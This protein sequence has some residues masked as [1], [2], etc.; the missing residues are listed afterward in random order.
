VAVLTALRNVLVQLNQSVANSSWLALVKRALFSAFF[1]CIICAPSYAQG[2]SSCV[3]YHSPQAFSL[4]HIADGDSFSIKPKQKVRILGID[5]YEWQQSHW[6]EL[7]K[8]RLTEL[9][10]KKYNQEIVNEKGKDVDTYK[11]L[12]RHVFSDKKN[13][14]ESLLEQGLVFP[15]MYQLHGKWQTCYLNIAKRAEKASKGIWKQIEWH[16]IKSI[17]AK[18][19]QKLL[20]NKWRYWVNAKITKISHNNKVVVVQLQQGAVLLMQRQVYLRFKQEFDQI[21][22]SDNIKFRAKVKSTK[23]QLKFWINHIADIHPSQ[24]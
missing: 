2:Q 8:Q 14:A 9:L 10:D 12:L 17:Q 22:A 1:V 16:T 19:K 11:R 15:L 6:S 18:L 20:N 23:G 21:F 13:V 24:Y 5:A 4:K 7:A 3:N